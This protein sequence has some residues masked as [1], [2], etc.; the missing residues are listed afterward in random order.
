LSYEEKEI[1]MARAWEKLFIYGSLLGGQ[2]DGMRELLKDCSLSLGDARMQA[3]LYSLGD[4]PAAVL[5]SDSSNGVVGELRSIDPLSRRALFRALDD[6]EGFRGENGPR[7]E[8]RRER[9]LVRDAADVVHRP[10]AYVYEADPSTL[11]MVPDGDW[12]AWLDGADL[13]RAKRES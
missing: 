8:F 5:S 13:T 4:Y 11:V 7:G 3:R 12:L 1:A 2:H 9:V 10:W 6:Y